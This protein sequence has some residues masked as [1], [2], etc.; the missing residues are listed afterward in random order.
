MLKEK[1]RGQCNGCT[2]RIDTV[3]DCQ[4]GGVFAIDPAD[5][6]FLT[7]RP[8]LATKLGALQPPIAIPTSRMQRSRNIFKLPELL[9]SVCF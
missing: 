4:G 6:A 5:L 1:L 3:L 9:Y 2:V 8:S 7:A